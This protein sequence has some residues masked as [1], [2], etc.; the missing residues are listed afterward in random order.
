MGGKTEPFVVFF[1]GCSN[2]VGSFFVAHLLWLDAEAAVQPL[3][4]NIGSRTLV[5]NV[6]KVL[7]LAVVIDA[8][9]VVVVHLVGIQ[10]VEL[11]AEVIVDCKRVAVGMNCSSKL[12]KRCRHVYSAIDQY[13]AASVDDALRCARRPQKC[14]VFPR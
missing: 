2:Q 5:N 8:N 12:L 9:E 7:H 1:V 6:G 10:R 13:V 11:G 14:T 4:R 3:Q